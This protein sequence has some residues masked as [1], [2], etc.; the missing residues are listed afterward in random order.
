MKELRE[1]RTLRDGGKI[2]TRTWF[3]AGPASNGAVVKSPL[4]RTQ[5][6]LTASLQAA[7]AALAKAE[8][9]FVL[10]ANYVSSDL[11]VSVPASIAYLGIT[12]ADISI[13]LAKCRTISLDRNM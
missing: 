7:A 10:K 4:P 8:E 5:R 13:N 12:F 6:A 11:Q 9:A 2:T 1:L 3:Q